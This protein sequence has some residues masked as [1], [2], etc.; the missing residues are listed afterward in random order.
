MNRSDSA[1]LQQSIQEEEAE[2][3]GDPSLELVSEEKAREL[4]RPA[5]ATKIMSCVQTK[6]KQE[7]ELLHL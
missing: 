1:S 4:E 6:G 7:I 2:F 3:D 5:W